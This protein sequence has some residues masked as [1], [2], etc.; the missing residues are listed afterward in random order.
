MVQVEE[1]PV[2]EKIEAAHMPAQVAKGAA[3]ADKW[4]TG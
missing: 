2:S 1:R 4:T 3:E